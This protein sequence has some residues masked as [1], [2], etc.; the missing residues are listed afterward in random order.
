MENQQPDIERDVA[1]WKDLDH[2]EGD[3]KWRRGDIAVRYMPNAKRGPAD[4]DAPTLGDLAFQVG[5]GVPQI[6]EYR[7]CSAFYPPVVRLD[8]QFK[9][10]TWSH[11]NAARRFSGGKLENAEELL[12]EA[13]RLHLNNVDEFKKHLKAMFEKHEDDTPELP[14]PDIL[15]EDDMPDVSPEEV[16]TK[17]FEAMWDDDATERIMTYDVHDTSHKAIKG[18]VDNLVEALEGEDCELT[19]Y[20]QI[21]RKEE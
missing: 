4:E 10:L 3:V 19:V 11:F 16:A 7:S 13:L 17:I 15:T 14:D 12:H 2:V 6:S 8:E 21:K 9:D 20:V 1:E 5:M 18:F